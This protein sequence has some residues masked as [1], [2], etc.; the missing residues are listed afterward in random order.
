MDRRETARLEGKFDSA[1][2]DEVSVGEELKL[3]LMN[4]VIVRAFYFLSWFFLFAIF[5]IPSAIGALFLNLK[6]LIRSFRRGSVAFIITRIV[7]TAVVVP[8]YCWALYATVASY[9]SN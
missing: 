7:I 6:V 2:K 9:L 8:A 3:D 4:F 1:W 5:L